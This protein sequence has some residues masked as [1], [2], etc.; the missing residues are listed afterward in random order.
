MNTME[1]PLSKGKVA[2]VDPDD[3]EE[4]SKHKW[5]TMVGKYTCYA[6]R[7]VREGKKKNMVSMHRQIHGLLKGDKRLVDHRNH[8][9][10]DNRRSN[11]R[12]CGKS[13]NAMN[14]AGR[15]G[16]ASKYKGVCVGRWGKRWQ[17]KINTIVDGKRKYLYLGTHET[18]E[19]AAR[20]YDNK[21]KELHGEF[22]LLN[23]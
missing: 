11:T 7:S 21:A 18:E 19:E 1:I 23:F 13:E 8:N 6:V 9:G 22:A 3:Y 16:T 5:H 2:I 17:A 12:V 10:L 20:A 15:K 4:L 14:S